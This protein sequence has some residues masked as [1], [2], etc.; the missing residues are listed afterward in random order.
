M[1]LVKSV[2]LC[3]FV[4]KCK[5]HHLQIVKSNCNLNAHM[6]LC[7]VIFH[8][9]FSFFNDQLRL[10]TTILLK[11]MRFEEKTC[12]T[13]KYIRFEHTNNNNKK[14]ILFLNRI[15]KHLNYMSK[16]TNLHTFFFVWLLYPHCVPHLCDGVENT[17]IKSNAICK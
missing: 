5:I 7:F 17:S 1:H 6:L 4:A 12:Q 9:Y 3:L 13:L 2:E 11:C 10:Q 14:K 8:I 16:C 15:E